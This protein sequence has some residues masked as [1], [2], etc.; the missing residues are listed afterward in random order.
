M[1]LTLC[2]RRWVFF[3][4]F[5]FFYFLFFYRKFFFKF[6]ESLEKPKTLKTLHPTPPTFSKSLFNRLKRELYSIHAIL[7]TPARLLLYLFVFFFSF[8]LK[9][10][11]DY[12]KNT[13]QLCVCNII[14][15]SFIQYIVWYLYKYICTIR[16]LGIKIESD[17]SFFDLQIKGIKRN[18]ILFIVCHLIVKQEREKKRIG[19]GNWF[20]SS[21]LQW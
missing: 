9:N 10:L 20:N 16:V 21:S 8:G 18:Q 7:W 1:R 19:N 12:T 11:K 15:R 4:L 5:V 13:Y 6:S 17:F 14:Y 2:K 3:Y